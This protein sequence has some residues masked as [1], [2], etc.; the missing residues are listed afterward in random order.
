MTYTQ[1]LP[2]DRVSLS[3]GQFPISNFDGNRYLGNQQHNFINDVFTQNGSATYAAAGLGA[4]GQWSPTPT[5]QL[6]LGFQYPNSASVTTLS[7]PGLDS[8]ENA[9]LGYAQWTPRHSG[10][11]PGQYSLT[12]YESPSTPQQSATRGWSVNAVQDLDEIWAV[13]GRANSASGYAT[14]VGASYVLGRA[15]NDPLDR[16][17]T[18]Q[19]GLA[20]G[21]SEASGPIAAPPGRR[22]EAILEAYWSWTLFGGLLFTPD[23]QFYLEPAL[24]ANGSSAWVLSLRATL[25]L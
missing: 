23:V 4:Y 24:D 19:I 3:V 20:V 22:G 18:D 5:I 15:V 12:Y 25:M 14:P 6:A 9:W 8:G 13:F 16:S 1:A 17:P 21:Y 7:V 10:L 11:G 2:S